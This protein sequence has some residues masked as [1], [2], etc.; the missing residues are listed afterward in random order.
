MEG[1]EQHTGLLQ[2]PR[3]DFDVAVPSARR[4]SRRRGYLGRCVLCRRD[5]RT[6]GSGAAVAGGSCNDYSHVA[7]VAVRRF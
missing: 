3:P 2:D 4:T 6:Q 7:S 1:C 5:F